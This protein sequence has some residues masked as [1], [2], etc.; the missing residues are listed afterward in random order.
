VLVVSAYITWRMYY[1]ESKI[2]P[3]FCC[4]NSI[5]RTGD[6]TEKALLKNRQW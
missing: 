3:Q 4:T 5:W 6:M 1:P 2:L